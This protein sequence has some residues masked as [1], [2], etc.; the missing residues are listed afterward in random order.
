LCDVPEL[1]LKLIS[2]IASSLLIEVMPVD[3]RV[4]GGDLWSN[5]VTII[6]IGKKGKI[7]FFIV[8]EGLVGIRRRSTEQ[9]VLRFFGEF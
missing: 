8:T 2:C 9:R 7:S 4:L 5:N 3:D 6:V 1:V